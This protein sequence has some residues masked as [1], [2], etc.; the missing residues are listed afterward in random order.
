MSESAGEYC[1]CVCSECGGYIDDVEVDPIVTEQI[2]I[3]DEL[4]QFMEIDTNVTTIVH[5][6]AAVSRY[7]NE[8][9]LN[10]PANSDRFF[11]DKPL[12]ALLQHPSE[13]SQNYTEYPRRMQHHFLGFVDE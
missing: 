9:K 10:D 12:A 1:E 7:I 8:N 3:S 2:L 11:L 4:R 13:H 5:A 6:C